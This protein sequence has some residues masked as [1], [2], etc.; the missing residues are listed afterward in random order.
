M[1]IINSIFGFRYLKSPSMKP[2]FLLG[3]LCFLVASCENE[4]AISGEEED[5]VVQI[6]ID[7][8]PVMELEEGKELTSKRIALG[9][10]LFFD[11]ILSRDQTISC[12][13]LIHI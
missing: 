9:R 10:K 4:K 5:P 8:F 13:S 7:H 12:L 11:P 3:F 6:R 2:F 1:A